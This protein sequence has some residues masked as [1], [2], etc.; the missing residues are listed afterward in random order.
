MVDGRIW[1]ECSESNRVLKVLEARGLPVSFTPVFW[2]GVRESNAPHL[3]GNQGPFPRRPTPRCWCGLQESNLLLCGGTAGPQ[4]IDQARILDFRTGIEPASLVLQTSAS[5]S[6]SRK[7]WPGMVE[8][9]HRRPCL[10]HGALPLSYFPKLAPAAGLEPALFSVNSR[11]RSPGVLDRNVDV[12]WLKP[13][14]S[15]PN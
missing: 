7:F 8:S 14:D 5:P 15:N 11:A 4:P 10:Q 3:G 12:D 9:N 13:R 6:G 2:C 1:R